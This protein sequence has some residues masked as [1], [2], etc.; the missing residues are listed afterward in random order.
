[1]SGE[2]RRFAFSLLLS[3]LLH[4]PL[5]ALSAGG[6]GLGLPGFDFPWRDRRIEATE[7]RVVL[8]PEQPAVTAPANEPVASPSGGQAVPSPPA[9]V[10]PV[11]PPVEKPL[12]VVA[13]A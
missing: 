13:P 9:S 2:R 8:V 3:L 12:A 4:A 5:L 11:R 1:M 7:L 10:P 6:T